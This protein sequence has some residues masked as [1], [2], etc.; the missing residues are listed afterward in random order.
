MRG[1]V[2]LAAGLVVILGTGS[3]VKV[4]SDGTSDES[5][6]NT[7]YKADQMRAE[8]TERIR[9]ATPAEKASLLVDYFE[10][11]TSLY[12]QVGYQTIDNWSALEQQRQD[13]VSDGEVR[14][15]VNNWHDANRAFITAHDDNID[16]AAREI[17][18]ANNS[19]ESFLARLDALLESYRK[20]RSAVLSPT[21]TLA[22]YEYALKQLEFEVG[23]IADQY[24]QHLGSM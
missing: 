17:R 24:R 19:E 15:M 4:Y 9:N 10:R 20:V 2:F 8:W 14:T 16:Y 11:V 6:L 3:C 23:E 22:E 18:F 12:F 1:L 13:A 7:N 5:G 21:G